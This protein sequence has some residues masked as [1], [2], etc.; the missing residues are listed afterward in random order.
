MHW[1]LQ[2]AGTSDLADAS[3]MGEAGYEANN[4]KVHLRNSQLLIWELSVH[5]RAGGLGNAA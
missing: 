3:R 4:P 1:P 5:Q 2:S